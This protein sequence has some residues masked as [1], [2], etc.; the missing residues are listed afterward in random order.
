MIDITIARITHVEW[1]YQ[2][3]RLLHKET[4]SASLPSYY[5][6]ELG[7][8]LYGE[9]L[10]NY[11]EI[12][13]IGYLVESHKR[14]HDA[15]DNVIEWHNGSKFNS[16]KTAQAEFDFRDALAMSKEIVHHLTMLEFK[17]LQ[18]YQEAQEAQEA[19]SGSL[20]NTTNQPWQALKSVI[21]ERS[22]RLN[23]ARFSL[24]LLK[25]DIIK[26]FARDTSQP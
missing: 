23:I 9:G 22:S 5:D 4:T 17:I 18:K 21:G 10:R 13:E 15:A 20:E 3:E 26:S 6:C 2:L 12:P 16:Q 19:V 1:V 7:V 24:D 14:F 8:W 11:K 25:K